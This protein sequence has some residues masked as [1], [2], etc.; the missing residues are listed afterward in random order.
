LLTCNMTGYRSDRLTQSSFDCMIASN[1][2]AGLTLACPFLRQ[3]G[4]SMPSSYY[5]QP[6]TLLS[7]VADMCSTYKVFDHPVYQQLVWMRSSLT[8]ARAA[9]REII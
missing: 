9:F 5:N 1:A 6:A 8:R 2:L 4:S 7:D 3:S